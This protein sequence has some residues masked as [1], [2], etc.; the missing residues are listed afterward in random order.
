MRKNALW[1]IERL[2]ALPG[3]NNLVVTTNGSQ[4]DRFA[5][6]LFA[7]GVKRINISLDTLRP[8]RFRQITRIGDVHK[9]LSGI[10]AARA[11]GFRR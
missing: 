1:L 8:E 3:L 5:R 11:A 9:V 2:G 4:L 10:A 7:A 6:P